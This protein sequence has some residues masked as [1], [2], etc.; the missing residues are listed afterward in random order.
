MSTVTFI[1]DYGAHDWYVGVMKGVVN[2][3]D[4]SATLIDVTHE[5]KLNAVEQAAL[6]LAWSYSYFPIGTVHVVV[7]DPGGGGPKEPI[8]LESR[9][10]YFIGPDNGVFTFVDEPNSKV[11][12]LDKRGFWLP[13]VSDT[14]HG[15]DIYAP[16]AGYMSRGSA[17]YQVG[18]MREEKIVTLDISK[19]TVEPDGSLSGQ[20]IH[21][22]R[23]G[24]CLTNIPNDSIPPDKLQQPVQVF[25]EKQE[26]DCI[27]ARTYEEGAAAQII[28]L[29][30]SSGLLELSINKDRFSD[31]YKVGKGTPIKIVY[32]E[33]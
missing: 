29:R 24:N 19:M 18:S 26:I 2:N 12:S 33:R 5:I 6:V 14:F 30:G 16:I 3:I 13:H 8:L 31:K 25:C 1:T 4:S 20:I 11:Y 17:P 7:V 32:H 23:F 21:V 9:G 15:R 10:H 27:F 28:V 22:N